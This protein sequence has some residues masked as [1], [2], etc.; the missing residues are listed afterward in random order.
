MTAE[1]H[2]CTRRPAEAPCANI[3]HST[4]IT[5][6]TPYPLSLTTF[7]TVMTSGLGAPSPRTGR[8]GGDPLT[9][10]RA[11]RAWTGPSH[12]TAAHPCGEGGRDGIIDHLLLPFDFH[13]P[14][15]LT[16]CPLPSAAWSREGPAL[17]SFPDLAL[18]P[19]L[20]LMLTEGARLSPTTALIARCGTYL[21]PWSTPTSSMLSFG[22][23]QRRVVTQTKALT[24]PRTSSSH[25]SA[26]TNSGPCKVRVIDH[27]SYPNGG[28]NSA[29]TNTL[30]SSTREWTRTYGGRRRGVAAQDRPARR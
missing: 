21:Q 12:V 10:T 24:S 30:I 2:A 13:A 18:R 26:S 23:R 20:H 4:P 1:L 5:P 22:A 19:R 25:H 29:I 8:G 28:V 27:H 17:T 3:W 14:S 6:T 16:G 9:P 11:P 7:T 15:P